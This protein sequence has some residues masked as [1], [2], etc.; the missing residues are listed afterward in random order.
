ML[1]ERLRR[2]AIMIALAVLA[3]GCAGNASRPTGSPA[4][5]GRDPRTAAALLRIAAVFNDDYDSGVY[6]PVYDRW[7]A[8]S[9][10]I[11]SR[12][13]YIRRH[14]ECPSAPVTAR[15]EGVSRGGGGAW[16]VAYEISGVHLIDYWF[17]VSGRWVFDLPLSNP[18][19][20]RL[21][22]LP[23]RKYVAVMGCAH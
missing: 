13:E 15:V 14:E 23:P 10:A 21:Y 9:Q 5:R 12:A 19:A 6:G 3:A 11:I 1:E 20:V 7:D 16:L 22:R 8:R 17:Y 4:A 18:G 2:L